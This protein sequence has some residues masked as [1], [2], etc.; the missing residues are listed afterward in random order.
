MTACANSIG[1]PEKKELPD[2]LS[3]TLDVPPTWG[4]KSAVEDHCSFRVNVSNKRN[5]DLQLLNVSFV[6][7]R[8]LLLKGDGTEVELD[9]PIKNLHGPSTNP[10]ITIGPSSGIGFKVEMARPALP[11]VLKDGTV[12]LEVR[13]TLVAGDIVEDRDGK[14]GYLDGFHYQLVRRL[15]GAERLLKFPPPAAQATPSGD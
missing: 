8:F 10:G 14:A 2:Q 5:A 1:W 11:A 15:S 12:V 13:I 3:V 4:S 7:P 6:E 9:V